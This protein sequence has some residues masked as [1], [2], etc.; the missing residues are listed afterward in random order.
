MKLDEAKNR[1]RI[2]LITKRVKEAD[3][4]AIKS[5]NWDNVLERLEQQGISENKGAQ[6]I[7]RFFQSLWEENVVPEGYAAMFRSMDIEKQR[8][9]AQEFVN[10][11]G[12]ITNKKPKEVVSELD[13]KNFYRNRF[14]TEL[15]PE[16]EDEKK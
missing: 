1:A 8:K 9:W 7:D 12:R 11:I 6:Y 3:S 15:L 14:L 10:S 4:D 16:R 5:G 13:K 2:N